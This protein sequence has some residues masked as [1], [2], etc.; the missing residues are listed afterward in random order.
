MTTALKYRLID[1]EPLADVELFLD[2]VRAIVTGEAGPPM[3][4]QG[5]QRYL[6]KEPWHADGGYHALFVQRL[7]ERLHLSGNDTWRLFTVTSGTAALRLAARALLPGS[8]TERREVLMPAMTVSN[9]AEALIAEGYVP[10]LV[11]VDPD[12]WLIDLASA[13]RALSP[14]TIGLVSVDWLGTSVAPAPL[15]AFCDE[16]GLRWISDSA[17]SFGVEREGLPPVRHADATVFSTGYPKVFHTGGRGGLLVIGAEAAERLVHDAGGALRNEPLAELQ[18]LAGLL[19]LQHFDE[20]LAR[21]RA[22]GDC[23]L[24]ALEPARGLVAQRVEDPH[25][26]NRYQLSMRVSGCLPADLIALAATLGAETSAERM[27]SLDQHPL[28]AGRVATPVPLPVSRAL[29]TSSLTLPMPH[30]LTPEAASAIGEA[31]ATHCTGRVRTARTLPPSTAGVLAQGLG[32]ARYWS[33]ETGPIAYRDAKGQARMA[34]RVLAPPDVMI[35]AQLSSAALLAAV[36]ATDVLEVGTVVAG[37]LMIRAICTCGSLTLD[38]CVDGPIARCAEGGSSANVSVCLGA[39]GTVT[40]EKRCAHDGIDGNGRPW[41][42]RQYAH[43]TAPDLE[44]A[45]ELFVRPTSLRVQNGEAIVELPYV[46]SVSVAEHLLAGGDPDHVL[47]VLDDLIEHL[48]HPVW[49]AGALPSDGQ[50]I[51]RVHLERM[52]RRLELAAR[53]HADLRQALALDELVLDGVRL[54]GFDRVCRRLT[55][56]DAWRRLEPRRLGLLHGD[57]NLYNVLCLREQGHR[58]RARLID[59]RGTKLWEGSEPS[60]GPERGDYSYDLGKI[61]FS[62]SGF[63]AIRAGLLTASGSASEG[64]RLVQTQDQLGMP[65]LA[66]CAASFMERCTRHPALTALRASVGDSDE[67]LAQR[68]ALAEAANFVADAACALGRDCQ[69]EVMPL[70]LT[71]LA[72]LNAVAAWLEHASQPLPANPLPSAPPAGPVVG[73]TAIRAG[74]T[75]QDRLPRWDIVEVVVRRGAV[76]LAQRLLQRARGVYLPRQTVISVGHLPGQ[77]TSCAD[78]DLP[79]VIIHGIDADAGPVEALALAIQRTCSLLTMLGSSAAASRHRILTLLPGCHRDALFDRAGEPLLAAAARDQVPLLQLLAAAHQLEG[80]PGGRWVLTGAGVALSARPLV[81]SGTRL[82]TLG[83]PPLL[84]L[85]L[86][87]ALAPLVR[88]RKFDQLAD[89]AASLDVEALDPGPEALVRL[90]GQRPPPPDSAGVERH[91]SSFHELPLA[92]LQPAGAAAFAGWLDAD[93]AA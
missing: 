60:E 52:Q 54:L 15:R 42:E 84:G 87:D 7:R 33:I 74:L 82:A 72:K 38:T 55:D 66:H 26:T 91:W 59:P 68:V 80:P 18:C 78:I 57:L 58:L 81:A 23:Y 65:G 21:R 8:A 69:H 93:G 25:H 20:C 47:N 86:P 27:P 77:P 37:P 36:R 61:A 35:G 71:G 34:P 62:L 85:Y 83:G 50:Y 1:P 44:P 46:H 10:V 41:L 40:I 16:H 75:V 30:G 79:A 67:T 17:Q 43:L 14:R 92:V 3:P 2:C 89:L 64:F 4:R 88:R 73:L 56:C 9:T 28:L 51:R 45:A 31:L 5:P 32:A 19:A 12:T 39:D 90:F 53:R 49:G 11:D 76:P 22:L 70:F 29:A 6:V 24:R 48:A 63:I 13:R